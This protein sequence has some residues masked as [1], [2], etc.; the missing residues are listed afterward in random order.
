MA[1]MS[2]SSSKQ[3]SKYLGILKKHPDQ[4]LLAT[5]NA[6]LEGFEYF[7]SE[8]YR[9]NNEKKGNLLTDKIGAMPI[10]DL[11]RLIW[12]MGKNISGIFGARNKS[13]TDI[14]EYLND[15]EKKWA[16][17]CQPGKSFG[18]LSEY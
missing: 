1:G 8:A 14:S 16:I 5:E 9:N 7:A 10:R 11:P 6:P 18:E 3:E 17:N 13:F 2:P 15:L 12:I 4:V